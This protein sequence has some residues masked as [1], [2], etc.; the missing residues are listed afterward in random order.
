MVYLTSGWVMTLVS[1]P[2]QLHRLV[3]AEQKRGCGKMITE[4]VGS[5]RCKTS[6]SKTS[7]TK[8]LKSRHKLR[9]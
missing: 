9:K 3:S 7:S 1:K 8:N 6:Q 4:G 2:V 5:R